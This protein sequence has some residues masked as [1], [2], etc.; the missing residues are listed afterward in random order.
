MNPL[1]RKERASRRFWRRVAIKGPQDCWLWKG[2]LNW[3]GQA[4]TH[5][6]G[7]ATLVHRI[8]MELH[9][10]RPLV[11]PTRQ[12]DKGEVVR[13]SCDCSFCVN[14]KH[15]RLGTQADN[16]KD[17]DY[18]NRTCRGEHRPASKLTKE[19]VIEIRR[20][21]VP[22]RYGLVRLAEEYSVNFTTIDAIIKR[23]SW[24]HVR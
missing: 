6:E 13:H 18:R 20:K 9:L 10:G 11:S 22:Q 2:K 4:Q 15:L 19:E 21:Y 1:K 14:P 8:A 17:R 16:I 5:W 24:K 3:C 23:K 12:L 7:Q